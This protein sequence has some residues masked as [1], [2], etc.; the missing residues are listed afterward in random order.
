[1]LNEILEHLMTRAHALPHEVSAFLYTSWNL[2][3]KIKGEI[4]YVTS[5]VVKIR[6]LYRLVEGR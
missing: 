6:I 1:M 5:K 4:P 2:A 3:I